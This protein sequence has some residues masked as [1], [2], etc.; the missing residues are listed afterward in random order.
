M[1]CIQRDRLDGAKQDGRFQLASS[2]AP[3]TD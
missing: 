3:S 1:R 2:L